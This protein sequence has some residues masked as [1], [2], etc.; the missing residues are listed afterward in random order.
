M[1][2]LACGDPVP[3]ADLHAL[4]ELAACH[5]GALELARPRLNGLAESVGTAPLHITHRPKTT[6]TIIEKLRRHGDMNLARMQDLAGIR[7]VGALSFAEQDLLADEIMRRFPPDPRAPK[8][9]D[10]RADPS[11]GYR[12]LHVVVSLE[13][14]TIE[15]QVRTFMQHVWADLMER[16]ADRLG[17]QIRY[18]QPPVPP[19]G[20]SQ[21][22]AQ[23]LVNAMMETAEHWAAGEPTISEE[24]ALD[25][26]QITESV[27]RAV[28]DTLRKSGV[29]L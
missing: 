22:A 20:M 11:H 12:A 5:L 13:G 16:L 18:G 1:N 27:W 4:E 17:R 23:C 7:I 2:R 24:A 29:D 14:V 10:R 3:D 25:V 19:A 8:I 15:V 26:D 9:S 6:Q 21:D 28:A